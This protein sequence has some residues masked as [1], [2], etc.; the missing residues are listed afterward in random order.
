MVQRALK[1]TTNDI[2]QLHLGEVGNLM[3]HSLYQS[4]TVELALTTTVDI[5]KP[6]IYTMKECNP[7]NATLV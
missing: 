7:N 1:H 3:Q 6:P 2:T 5:Q 4:D